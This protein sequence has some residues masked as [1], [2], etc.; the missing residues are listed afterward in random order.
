MR[1]VTKTTGSVS[2]SSLS[3]CTNCVTTRLWERE[4]SYSDQK[5]IHRLS[6][7]QRTLHS[8]I[9]SLSIQPPPSFPRIAPYVSA[10]LS[11][12][13]AGWKEWGFDSCGGTVNTEGENEREII[14]NNNNLVGNRMRRTEGEGD[15]GTATSIT[16][17]HSWEKHNSQVTTS[18]CREQRRQVWHNVCLYDESV[19]NKLRQR[20]SCQGCSAAVSARFW[21]AEVLIQVWAWLATC[22]KLLPFS[23][24][25]LIRIQLVSKRQHFVLTF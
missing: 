13:L 25:N 20:W 23:L 24:S 12:F 15:T 16:L 10:C 11:W 17:S 14:K 21:Y 1:P 8:T 19:E 22:P 3:L 5:Q 6:S 4:P 9:A 18:T 7:S 2:T